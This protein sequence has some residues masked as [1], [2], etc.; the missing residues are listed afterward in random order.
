MIDKEKI[1]NYMDWVY[2]VNRMEVIGIAQE[3]YAFAVYGDTD[4]DLSYWEMCIV[5]DLVEEYIDRK[6]M[7]FDEKWDII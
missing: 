4:V 1:F 3:A 7:K 6:W 2:L 5:S